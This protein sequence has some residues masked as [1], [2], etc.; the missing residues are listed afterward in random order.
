M[1][2][3]LIMIV[4]THSGL[5]HLAVSVPYLHY[6]WT[7]LVY[8][9]LCYLQEVTNPSNTTAYIVFGWCILGVDIPF[10][11]F[12]W[13]PHWTDLLEQVCMHVNIVVLHKV[14]VEHVGSSVR[15]VWSDYATI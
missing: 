13:T 15:G 7:D 1:Y 3:I 10:T 5:I 11:H 4:C 2:V 9:L 8:K 6:E 14:V 12:K